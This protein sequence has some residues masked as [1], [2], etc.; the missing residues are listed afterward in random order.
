MKKLEI[1]NLEKEIGLVK[2][3]A[4]KFR[5]EA[6]KVPELESENKKLHWAI[7]DKEVEND[8]MTTALNTL[9]VPK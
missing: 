4:M 6:D 9:Q 1:D 5:E 7:N 3:E 8:A 2:K